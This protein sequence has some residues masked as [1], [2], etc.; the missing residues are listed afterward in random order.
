MG[1]AC[2]TIFIGTNLQQ[3]QAVGIKVGHARGETRASP[4]REVRLPVAQLFH[5]GPSCRRGRA[6]RSAGERVRACTS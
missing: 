3:V 5:P 1:G 2:V 6:K 4:L